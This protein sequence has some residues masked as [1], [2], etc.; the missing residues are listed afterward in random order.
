VHSNAYTF[1]FAAMVTVVCSVL[2]ASA[3]TLLKP[4]QVENEKLDSQK[5]ILTSVGIK[6]A[7]GESFSKNQIQDMYKKNIAGFV[8]DLQGNTVEG[9]TPAQIDPKKDKNLLPVFKLE[10]DG[11]LKAYV[12]PVSGKGLWS[13]VYAYMALETDASTVRGVTFYKHGETPGLGGEIEKEWFTANFKGKKIF[14]EE[15][16]LISIEI[17]K[18]KVLNDSPDAY[19]QV[20][21]I[22][23]S[24]LTCRG[25]NNFI[26][27][28]LKR[29]EP[30]LKK[31]METGKESVN[32]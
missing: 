13:T 14:D 21:G 8:I 17:V 32:G 24:T 22:S 27:V 4:F 9:K 2:L 11:Q 23:G 26:K 19:H 31:I 7:D 16:G 18:G 20:D 5:N 3:A 6:P 29:Y 25:I 1:R 28:N 12:L 30:F 15:G 10:T